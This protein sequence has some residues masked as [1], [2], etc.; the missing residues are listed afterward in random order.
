MSQTV[1][2]CN[3][4]NAW[5]VN[6]ITA[7]NVQIPLE[8]QIVECI[9]SASQ[10]VS[11][12]QHAYISNSQYIHTSGQLPTYSF[13]SQN[14]VNS[15]TWSSDNN[16]DHRIPHFLQRSG[17]CQSANIYRNNHLR[18]Q[19]SVILENYLMFNFRENISLFN[20]SCQISNIRDLTTLIGQLRGGMDAWN[21]W[22]W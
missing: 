11:T 9:R 4:N 15:S 12:I 22:F 10:S 20:V 5:N 2:I 21:K 18:I 7:S 17:H 3:K 6:F 1:R 8:I 16:V 19:L 13:L 14:N